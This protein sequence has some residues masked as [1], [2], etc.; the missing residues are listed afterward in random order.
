MTASIAYILGGSNG[1]VWSWLFWVHIHPLASLVW[2]A[3]CLFALFISIEIRQLE[4]TEVSTTLNTRNTSLINTKQTI[5]GPITSFSSTGF[6]AT[7]VIEVIVQTPP[8]LSYRTT[9]QH[10]NTQA[11]MAQLP[12][13]HD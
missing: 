11:T 13:S 2:F 4:R 9:N 12:N 7:E 6:S 1:L 8:Q 3:F 10:Q 5:S